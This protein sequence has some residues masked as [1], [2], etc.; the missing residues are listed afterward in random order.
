MATRNFT[1]TQVDGE[2]E[3]Y[4][5]SGLLQGDDGDPCPIYRDD[6]IN[7]QVTGTTGTGGTITLQG[8]LQDLASSPVWTGLKSPDG[9]VTFS[10][11]SATSQIIHITNGPLAIRPL[12][13]G[14]DGGTNFVV[15]LLISRAGR[16]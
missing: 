1:H 8:T 12:V 13:A 7:V 6:R 4:V 15:T 16:P 3:R 14:G 10:S 2:C 9:L 11:L 5:W